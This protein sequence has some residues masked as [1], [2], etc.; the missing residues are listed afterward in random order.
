MTYL[1]VTMRRPGEPSRILGL[2]RR[3]DLHKAVKGGTD[4]GG[5][6]WDVPEP[7]GTTTRYLITERSA[8]TFR[9]L[10]IIDDQKPGRDRWY[11]RGDLMPSTVHATG[12]GAAEELADRFDLTRVPIVERG[13]RIRL[14]VW[15]APDDWFSFEPDDQPAAGTWT[16]DPNGAS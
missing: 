16:Y 4:H 8:M 1:N 15:P 12:D 11:R 9:V 3:D 10:Y 13:H 14:R 2:V 6:C 7:D 5:G